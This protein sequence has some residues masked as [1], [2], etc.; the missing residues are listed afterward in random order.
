MK[1]KQKSRHAVFSRGAGGLI[2]ALCALICLLLAFCSDAEAYEPNESRAAWTDLLAGLYAAC[3]HPSEQA[4]ETVDACAAK[5][6][7][8]LAFSLTEHFRQIWLR[9]DCPL[10]LFGRDDPAEVPARGRHAIVVLG[11]ELQNGKMTRELMGRC[12]A[13]A[14][15]ARA[16]PDSL[17]VLSGGA[18][19]LFNPLR[20]TEAGLMR[21]YLTDVC[22]LDPV[23]MR[24]DEK[25]SDTAE[26]ALNVFEIL[27]AENAETLTIVTSDYHYRRS[28]TLFCAMS[29]KYRLE[30]GYMVKGIS[31]FCWPAGADAFTIRNE[32][33][34]TVLQLGDILDLPP[35]QKLRLLSVLLAMR[36]EE[37]TGFSGG[38]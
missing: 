12:D 30:Q 35:A 8:E 7:S 3:T 22:G 38:E 15:L 13:A 6:E 17:I 31:G 33:R 4:E 11:H 18:T 26:N 21:A 24:L 27:R 16:F 5:L 23:R 28:L 9:G 14:A 1:T 34:Y 10:Y 29:E 25:A 32:V 20:R 19:G 37:D 2:R 36:A